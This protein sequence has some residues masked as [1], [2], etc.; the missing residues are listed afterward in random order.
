MLPAEGVL[1]AV[2]RWVTLLETG[3]SVSHVWALVRSVPSLADVSVT[4]YATAL[5]WLSIHGLVTQDRLIHVG[6]T[7]AEAHSA[8]FAQLIESIAPPWLI[9]ADALISNADD[10]PLDAERLAQTFGLD[11][12]TAYATIMGVHRKVDLEARAR[13]GLSGEV[14]LITALE[15]RWPGSTTHVS[16][17]DDSA[18]YDIQLT[19]PSRSWHLEVKTT[20]RRGRLTIHLTRNEY[21][22]SRR[23]KSWLL[24]LVGLSDAGEL[25][26]LATLRGDT[27]LPQ[28][29]HDVSPRGRWEAAAI[30]LTP[31]ELIRGLVLAD[32]VDGVLT[33]G[34]GT[35]EF[36]WLPRADSAG[37]RTSA[38][39]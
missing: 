12:E 20:A 9:D 2:S 10:L 11:A 3:D 23:D 22:T 27:L 29:P 26:A 13:I 24:V 5:D 6:N 8:L 21:V 7:A 35:S 14:A 31:S 28:V 19:L 36:A 39:K 32:A 17:F 37:P 30:D 15:A 33:V 34:A 18:G 4:Q 1:Q 16:I 38:T 25:A